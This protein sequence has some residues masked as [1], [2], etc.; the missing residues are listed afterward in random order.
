[1]AHSAQVSESP[2]PSVPA[3]SASLLRT[4][5]P[6]VA[7]GR[8][9][10]TCPT[11]NG[12]NTARLPGVV[13]RRQNLKFVFCREAASLRHCN[14]FGR[15]HFGR[16]HN[17]GSRR[18]RRRTVR[19][20]RQG[21]GQRFGQYHQIVLLRP[22]RKLQTVECLT[23]VGTEGNECRTIIAMPDQLQC[24]AYL[25]SWTCLRLNPWPPS[26]NAVE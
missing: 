6:P 23:L 18:P 25:R 4:L 13:G 15:S 16:R 5:T 2:R 19:R 9:I 10:W 8:G 17:P 7:Q 14:E 11:K 1:M 21:R 20:G 12:R 26:W 24:K 3:A 22:Q